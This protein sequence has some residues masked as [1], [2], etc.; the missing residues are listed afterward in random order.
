MKEKVGDVFS[1]AKDNNPVPG[2]TISREV[3]SGT[4]SITYFSLA[5][6]TDISAEIYSSYKL[7]L[8]A[9]GRM[10]VYGREGFIR[11]LNAGE[12]IVTLTD[13][14]MGMRTQKGVVYTEILIQK[15][16]IMNNTIKAGEVFQLAEVVPYQA[17]RIVNMDVVHNDKI[18]S[19]LV[20]SEMC[21]RDRDGEGNI[22]YEGKEHKIKA[23]EN[24][25]FAKGGRHFVKASEK[26]KMALLL[27]LD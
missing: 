11:E 3:Y 10:E 1:I 27:T 16:D 14:P 24:F 17:G 5:A 2:C 8:V 15:E 26:F 9:E 13:T 12:A 20:G 7:I 22:G 21:I 23:G 19:C 25:H 6:G 4:N 18:A